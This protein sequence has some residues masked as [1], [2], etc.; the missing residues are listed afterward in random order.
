[1]QLSRRDDYD[2]KHKVT[3]YKDQ[4]ESEFSV[5][6]LSIEALNGVSKSLGTEAI[7]AETEE[8]NR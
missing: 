5:E 8:R 1:M 3:A 2:G 6:K 4:E 7:R